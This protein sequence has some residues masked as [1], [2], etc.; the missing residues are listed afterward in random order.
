[1][2]INK[3]TLKAASAIQEA[4]KLA[5]GKR[6]QYMDTP[7]LLFV[8]LEQTETVIDPILQKIGVDKSTLE[9]EISGAL[10]SIPTVKLSKGSI[11]KL[12]NP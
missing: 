12:I 5:S 6:H 11:I 4:Q 9:K 7:H 10:N 1:M 2:D 8:L 3:F